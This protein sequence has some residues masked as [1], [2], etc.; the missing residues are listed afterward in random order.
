MAL[1][2]CH[3]AGEELRSSEASRCSREASRCLRA[4]P[5][6]AEYERDVCLASAPPDTEY[7]AALAA[8]LALAPPP[9]MR[10]PPMRLVEETVLCSGGMD[11]DLLTNP[12][13]WGRPG[14][15]VV[16]ADDVYCVAGPAGALQTRRIARV[17]PAWQGGPAGLAWHP[18]GGSIAVH[19]HAALLVHDCE[20]GRQKAFAVH[21]HALCC[22]LWHPDGTCYVGGAA[23][24]VTQH[25]FRRKD[26]RVASS[27]VGRCA[28]A[29]LRAS[30]S[31]RFVAAS[32]AG[33]HV[34]V[35]AAGV[36]G[37][38]PW[39]ELDVGCQV[40]R[41]MDWSPHTD[42]ELVAAK[43]DGAG[44]RVYRVA[45]GET[46]RESAAACAEVVDVAWL[47]G[48]IVSGHV[49]AG[50]GSTVRVWDAGTVSEDAGALS[51]RGAW[52]RASPQASTLYLAA[53]PDATRLASAAGPAEACV[54][55]W[56]VA[57]E[58]RRLPS[59]PP[60]PFLDVTV[61]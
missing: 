19:S 16:I 57:A 61:R 49:D 47:P 41:A 28:V 36:L 45:T 43:D 37:H 56:H 9:P 35:W 52:A 42:A 7:R 27:E 17:P 5:P 31:G 33:R 60:Q 34:T 18:G 53:A 29:T 3:E 50:A 46:A 44:L 22:A 40:L 14:L 23:G 20:T 11:E 30:A 51:A 13:A 15:G 26:S 12:M 8:A 48:G 32:G 24:R 2:C 54:Q 39:Q 55:L 10:A 6:P 58:A 59:A 25:D 1:G 4:A 38:R 21:A